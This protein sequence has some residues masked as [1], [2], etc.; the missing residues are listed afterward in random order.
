MQTLLSDL[1]TLRERGTF[2]GLMALLVP[3]LRFVRSTPVNGPCTV[4]GQSA[5]VLVQSLEDLWL[6]A[7]T[8]MP[9][10]PLSFFPPAAS[11]LT[12]FSLQEMAVLYVLLMFI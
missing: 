12:R 4:L 6:R 5:V 2:S 8:G 9:S 1:V 3:V 11:D 7:G 10:S